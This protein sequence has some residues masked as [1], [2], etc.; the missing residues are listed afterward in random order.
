MDTVQIKRK[1][2]NELVTKCNQLKLEVATGDNLSP[3][4]LCS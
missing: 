3:V 2:D 1:K 4:D